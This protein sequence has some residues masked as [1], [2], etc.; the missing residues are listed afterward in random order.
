MYIFFSYIYIAYVIGKSL[1]KNWEVGL[2]NFSLAHCV[3]VH[4]PIMETSCL[5]YADRGSVP[6]IREFS[7]HELWE[8]EEQ[9]LGR[10][11]R[12]DSQSNAQNWP[13]KATL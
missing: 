7:A 11:S 6:S 2:P 13:A 5:A 10:V 9:A 4:L 1:L 3:R 12:E 8:L